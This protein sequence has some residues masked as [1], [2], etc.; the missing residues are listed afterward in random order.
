MDRRRLPAVREDPDQRHGKAN[1]R[2]LVTGGFGFLG[3]Y[4]VRK[5]L[6]DGWHVHVLDI[7]DPSPEIEW[8]LGT[9]AANSLTSELGRVDDWSTVIDATKNVAPR[10]ILHLAAAMGTAR[11]STNPFLALQ[12]N[13]G[14]TLN[15]FEAARLFDVERVILFSSLGAL[16]PR[17]YEPI[18]ASHP[19][20][21]AR[22]AGGTGFYGASK[23]AA[24]AFAFAYVKSYRLD[25]RIVRPSM[26]YGLGMPTDR[27]T[28]ELKTLVEGVA[29]GRPV[30]I[31]TGGPLRRGFTHASDVAALAV[32]LLDAP[33]DVDRVFYAAT[34]E[35]LPTMSDVVSALREL[36][37]SSEITVGGA[38][39]PAQQ[40]EQRYR[41]RLDIT[42]GLNQLGWRPQYPDLPSGLSRYLAD[43]RAYRADAEL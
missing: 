24:E 40:D 26:A 18:D 10:A 1:R 32:A 6:E 21:L 25:V 19:T 31:P 2:A 4:V 43:Y 12:V 28:S 7:R 8:V 29:D 16:A 5:L 34:G 14:G 20:I 22:E 41:G 9:P 3:G 35:I 42:N 37:P 39:S 33:S 23:L 27:A 11:L 15:V 13:V 17:Q 30:E 36:V 38:L